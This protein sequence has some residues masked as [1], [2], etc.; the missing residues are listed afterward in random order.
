MG[1]RCHAGGLLAAIGVLALLM[2]PVLAQEWQ[3]QRGDCNSD[4]LLNV[5]DPIF[6]LNYLFVTD[7]TTPLCFDGCDANDNGTVNIADVV[8]V[9]QFSFALGPPPPPPFPACPRGRRE[10]GRAG[11]GGV[12]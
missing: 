1:S 10:R 12:R 5:S 8:Y 11:A 6:I 2:G 7:S 4:G 3:F 9:L